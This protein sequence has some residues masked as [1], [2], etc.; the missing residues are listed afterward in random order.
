M[1]SRVRHSSGNVFRDLGFSKVEADSL[2]LRGE[3]MIELDRAIRAKRLTQRAAAK[4]LG[5]SQPRVNDLLRG[6][7]ERFSLG[8]LVDLLSRMGRQ[9]KVTVAPRRK[10]A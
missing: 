10:A 9:V 7:I 8:A 1:A 2:L 3:L 4:I 5:V 6:R